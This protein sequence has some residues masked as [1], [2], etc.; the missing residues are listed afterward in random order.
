ME[1]ADV[2]SA[3]KAA[4][5]S[6]KGEGK[7]PRICLYDAVSSLPGARF[8]FEDMTRACREEGILTLV[9]AAQGVGMVDI[10]L[11]TLDPDFLVTNCHKW[12]LVPRGC[13]VF[14]V[15]FRNQALMTS[16]LPTSHGYVPKTGRFNPLPASKKTVFVNNFE[17]VG[18]LDNSPYLCVKDAIEW[19]EQALGGEEKIRRYLW[20]L[21]KEGGKKAASILGTEVMENSTGTLTNCSL[22]NVGLPL[23]VGAEG[24]GASGAG[25]EKESGE[26]VIPHSEAWVAWE[27]LTKVLV[28]EYKTFIPTYVVQGRFIAR[29]SAQVY[30]DVEDFEW[31]GNTLKQLC[32]RV[33]RGEYKSKH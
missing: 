12:L 20:T 18:T 11:G 15:P 10:N 13:A 31:A 7:R 25:T 17:Y 22:V 28:D 5:R 33:A 1:D 21:A 14:Y 29:L 19:R 8:P 26:P 30:L 3:F 4:V 24:A 32:S 27:W 2:I 16:T 23:L 9:D 6:A